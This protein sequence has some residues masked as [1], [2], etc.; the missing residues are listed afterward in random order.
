MWRSYYTARANGF[1]TR[2]IGMFIAHRATTTDGL[3]EQHA[4]LMTTMMVTGAFP[5]E[6]P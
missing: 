1:S 5:H 2:A 4:A 3:Y 6:I